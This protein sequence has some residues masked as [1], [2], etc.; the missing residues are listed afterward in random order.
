MF[1]LSRAAGHRSR[2]FT[3]QGWLLSILGHG[4]QTPAGGSRRSPTSPHTPRL[5]HRCCHYFPQVP[6][7][8]APY[9]SDAPRTVQ[10]VLGA[11]ETAISAWVCADVH[12]CVPTACFAIP[13]LEAVS[14]TD[15]SKHARAGGRNIWLQG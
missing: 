6:G 7:T 10:K 13:A 9:G 12:T 11:G 14:P 3:V 1:P 4:M 8:H 5:L 2:E 15:I